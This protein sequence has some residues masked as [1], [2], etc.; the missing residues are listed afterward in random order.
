[1]ASGRQLGRAIGCG[2]LA[3]ACALAVARASAQDRAPASYP[4]ATSESFDR[5]VDSPPELPSLSTEPPLADELDEDPREFEAAVQLEVGRSLAAEG[6]CELAVPRLERSL[7]LVDTLDVRFQ[8]GA[9]LHALGRNAEALEHV[10]R[11]AAQVDPDEDMERAQVALRILERARG[12]V[13]SLALVVEPAGALV[14]IDGRAV[15]GRGN[16][17]ARL[18]PGAHVIRAE[19]VGHRAI[20]RSLRVEAGERALRLVQLRRETPPNAVLQIDAD[21]PGAWARI[22]GRRVE[23]GPPGVP[24]EPGTHRIAIGARGRETR[25]RV[26]RLAG[27][28]RLR[29]DVALPEARSDE[30]TMVIA[31][32]LA[33]VGAGVLGAAIGFAVGVSPP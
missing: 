15:I 32:A 14:T 19:Y 5:E 4:L 6:R 12:E 2:C 13:A 9:C 18:D 31:G 20:V 11:F 1:M 24:L 28:E 22:D 8:L 23:V 25:D 21:A 29:L 26:V 33:L 16:R 17:V 10:E 30:T 7:E 3:L 27:G